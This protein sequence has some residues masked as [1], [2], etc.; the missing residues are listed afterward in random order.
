MADRAGILCTPNRSYGRPRAMCLG[1]FSLPY[2]PIRHTLRHY[3][4]RRENL[5][6]SGSFAHKRAVANLLKNQ[7]NVP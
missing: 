3:K 1:P 5:L 4:S 7:M 2:R 6:E